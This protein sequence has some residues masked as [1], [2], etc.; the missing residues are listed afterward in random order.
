M[1]KYSFL[2]Y[3]VGLAVGYF[4]KTNNLRSELRKKH[5]CPHHFVK[6]DPPGGYHPEERGWRCP[7]CIKIERVLFGPPGSGGNNAA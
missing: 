4:W 5:I 6:M 2:F 3:L 1:D 7:E